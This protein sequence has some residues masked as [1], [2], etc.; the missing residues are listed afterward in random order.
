MLSIVLMGR[1]WKTR[2]HSS[3]AEA[4]AEAEA[5]AAETDRK[6]LLDALSEPVKIDGKLPFTPSVSEWQGMR[7]VETERRS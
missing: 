6:A 2:A 7:V 3:F 4:R 1:G 5:L